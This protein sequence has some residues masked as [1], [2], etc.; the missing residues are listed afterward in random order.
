MKDPLGSPHS[1]RASPWVTRFLG[2]VRRGG[3]VLD[4]ACGGGRHVAA[5]LEAGLSVCAVDRDV[6][7]VRARF[8]DAPPDRLEIIEADL[9]DGREFPFEAGAFDGVIVTN[10]LWRP[11]L[12][13]IVDVVSA[14]GFLI[15]ET[16]RTGNERY[17]RPRNPEFLLRPG[18]LLAVVRDGLHVI[19]Y[20]EAHLLAPDRL[21]QRI[22]AVGPAHPWIEEPPTS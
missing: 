14:G 5:S 13:A 6:S 9:E 20:E 2:G 1:D 12:P 19:A 8:E 15:Y 11:L 3:R 10:Y 7:A 4:L 16:F 18:E 21:V 17:G 22:C